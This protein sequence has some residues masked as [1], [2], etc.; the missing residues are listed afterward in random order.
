MWCPMNKG[1]IMSDRLG[2]HAIACG[3][4]GERVARHNHCRDSLLQTAQQA[5]LG[6]VREPDEL[7]SG[8]D[9]W[10]AELLIPHWSGGR[11]TALDF[12]VIN[13]LQGA[14]V[15][16]TAVEG[17]SAGDHAHMVK[18][19]K[20]EQQCAAEGIHF[21][22]VV[23]DTFRGWHPSALATLKKLGHQ[24][25]RNVGRED[26]KVVRHLRQRLSILLVRDNVALLCARTPTYPSP[27]V[28]KDSD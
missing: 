1:R 13:P 11:D 17:G 7:L 20:Y 14:L 9:D 28:D 22:P 23:V 24:L 2:D 27:D 19:R 18:V 6:P 26:V 25:A 5:G 15:R 8:S 21:L 16:R 4:C 10:P 3:I 12:T